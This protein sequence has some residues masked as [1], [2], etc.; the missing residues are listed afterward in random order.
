MTTESFGQHCPLDS[1][2]TGIYSPNGTQRA[3]AKHMAGSVYPC[4][5][6]RCATGVFQ[7][8]ID[9]HALGRFPRESI[10]PK[11][12]QPSVSV[13]D[14]ILACPALMSVFSGSTTLNVISFIMVPLTPRGSPQSHYQL[15]FDI[16]PRKRS[17]AIG[18]GPGPG[19]LRR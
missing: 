11:R 10:E 3:C 12:I 2:A 14:D 13:C 15:P 16:I 7:Q 8:P 17:P 9:Y 6:F 19:Q 5:R 1:S 4:V 18:I